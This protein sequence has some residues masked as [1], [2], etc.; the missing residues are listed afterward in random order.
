VCTRALWRDGAGVE[1]DYGERDESRPALSITVWMQ[2][3]L[4]NFA[5]V[6]EAAGWIEDSQLQIVGQNDP[7]TGGNAP[8]RLA[9]RRDRCRPAVRA[10]RYY[11]G[12]LPKP[13]SSTAAVASL[14]S[15]LR[16]A[17]QPFRIP[18]PDKPEASATV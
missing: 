11:V 16:N 8:L 5:T 6:A 18:D 4:D 3:M 1:S 2:H 13:A 14:L 15:V 17:A 9:P 7:H 10:R 12:R